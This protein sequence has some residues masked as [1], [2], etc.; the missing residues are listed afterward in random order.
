VTWQHPATADEPLLT[1]RLELVPRVVGWLERRGVG[2]ITAHIHPD[3]HASAARGGSLDE[4]WQ[5]VWQ[6]HRAMAASLSRG[7]R[8]L[9][10]AVKLASEDRP[11]LTLGRLARRACAILAQPTCQLPK[12]STGGWHPRTTSSGPSASPRL[13]RRVVGNQ[14]PRH[15]SIHPRRRCWCRFLGCGGVTG[16]GVGGGG[17]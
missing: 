7:Q 3:H 13:V 16:H 2:T 8:R 1:V 9:S 14:R 11:T 10:R 5:V 15:R 17:G 4:Q 6:V 12:L